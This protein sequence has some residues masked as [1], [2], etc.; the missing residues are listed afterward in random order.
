M[1]IFE[2]V[3]GLYAIIAGLGISLLVHS[4][5]EMIER[6]SL[7]RLY[8]VQT[9]WIALIFAAHISS[10]FTFWH[11]AD[12]ETWT[13]LDVMLVLSVPILLYLV[14]H[15]AVPNLEPRH[16]T[17]LRAYYFEHHRWMQ[18]LLIAS[19]VLA[20]ASQYLILER[21]VFETPDIART[22]AIAVLIP[23]FVSSAPRVHAIQ[24]V[25]LAMLMLLGLSFVFTPIG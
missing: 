2:F 15:L 21:T 17:D 4:V 11:F 20:Q 24:A 22:V 13:P 18:G 16:D 8:W 1:A 6:R 3:I 7:L 25:L 12:Q 10:W 14:S 19:V 5:G 9:V 23:G